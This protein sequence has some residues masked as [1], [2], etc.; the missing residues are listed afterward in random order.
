ML[1][2]Q[3]ELIKTLVDDELNKE[4]IEPLIK[5]LTL[6][7]KY[8]IIP[9]Y[10]LQ[11][12]VVKSTKAIKIVLSANDN[13]EYLIETANTENHFKAV[14]YEKMPK[15]V[16]PIT[17][18][19][20]SGVSLLD[21]V[22]NKCEEYDYS[23]V[24]MI[25]GK[26]LKDA[27]SKKLITITKADIYLRKNGSLNVILQWKYD[28]SLQDILISPVP[29]LA[30]TTR[31]P[32]VNFAKTSKSLVPIIESIVKTYTFPLISYDSIIN[33][34]DGNKISSLVD[35]VKLDQMLSIS[36][37]S[38]NF[39]IFKD[40]IKQKPN[41]IRVWSSDDFENDTHIKTV[42]LDMYFKNADSS[43]LLI[44]RYVDDVVDSII[45]GENYE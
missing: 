42:A 25:S 22:Y 12:L 10:F 27:L 28:S 41:K 34:D 20:P 45:G 40:F 15:S 21:T 38:E 13:R 9:I 14:I 3:A 30:S 8:T 4:I 19:Y 17:L 31:L 43:S 24:Y 44:Y 7:N 16:T 11:F 35:K 5:E 36:K 23:S 18:V 2:N 6:I 29:S 32:L 1:N 26:E 39:K 37:A 33:K